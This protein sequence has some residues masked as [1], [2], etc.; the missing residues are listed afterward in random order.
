LSINNV[1]N[2][3]EDVPTITDMA[4]DKAKEEGQG[5]QGKSE[6]LMSTSKLCKGSNPTHRAISMMELI[7]YT[8]RYSL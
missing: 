6:K 4:K 5:V 3:E 1:E 7:C 8:C 2:I